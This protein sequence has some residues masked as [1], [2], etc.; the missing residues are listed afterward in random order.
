VLDTVI[1]G[2]LV[3]DGSGGEPRLADVGVH[4]GRIAAVG[5]LP[6]G[7]SAEEIAAAGRVVAPGF[8]DVHV[9]ADALLFDD[10]A[11]DAGL[12]QGVTTVILG[13]DGLGLA[14]TNAATAREVRESWAGILGRGGGA[15]RAM[16]IGAYLSAL[17][18]SVAPNV[19]MLLPHG[20]LRMSV[21][22]TD[23]R[24]ATPAEVGAMAE[25][26]RE[27]YAEGALGFS[28]G[29]DYVPCRWAAM[30]EFV[31]LARVAA[32]TGGPFVTHMRNYVEAAEPAIV[33]ALGIGEAA[34]GAVHIS[35]F[36]VRTDRTLPLVD[37]ARARGRDVTFDLYPYLAG[38]PS[39][40]FFLPAWAQHGGIDATLERLA[41][42]AVRERL[43]PDLEEAD[44]RWGWQ[45][46][47]LTDVG[48]GV[49]F[50]WAAGRSVAEIAAAAGT[51]VVDVVADVLIASGGAAAT[52]THHRHRTEADQARLVAH[53]GHI[54]ASDGVYVGAS[55]HP[56][57]A[58]AFARYLRMAL[59]DGTLQRTIAHLTRSAADRFGL[60][61][62]G[63]IA[64]GAAADLVVFDP[65]RVRDR[66]TY[67]APTLPPDGIEQVLVNG[68]RVVRDGSATGARAGRAIR[69]G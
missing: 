47:V 13:N 23:A 68:V 33:E 56:R 6:A 25:L 64:V 18:G 38:A 48:P 20:P 52:V 35:H 16:S 39:L 17:D 5:P 11:F 9:H 4:D 45:N 2:G 28:I 66:A 10:P 29:L 22:G 12:R 42:S 69:R 31:A 8:I 58:G 57:G 49:G 27:A 53:V 62:R 34:G 32:A 36:N 14:P 63:R 51:D 67:E 7:T 19:G 24:E 60:A 50:A 44:R 15:P 43:R 3:V 21:M 40:T 65:E 30:D 61:D 46:V 26:S 1:R 37:E 55:P 54:G 59:D 41:D